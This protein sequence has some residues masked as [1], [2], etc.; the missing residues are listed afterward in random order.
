MNRLNNGIDRHKNKAVQIL[1]S[2]I[3]ELLFI[4]ERYINPDVHALYSE[5]MP[6]ECLYTKF[7]QK[8]LM[9]LHQM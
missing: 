3:F 1:R 8:Q 2:V 9:P 4:L 7:H 6:G 5:W